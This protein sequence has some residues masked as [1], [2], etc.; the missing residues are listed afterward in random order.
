MRLRPENHGP[1]LSVNVATAI[2][3]GTTSGY[4]EYEAFG[5]IQIVTDTVFT[6]ATCVMAGG[7]GDKPIAAVTY[8]A[9]FILRKYFTTIHLASGVIEMVGL[10]D[11]EDQGLS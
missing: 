1:T 3:A 11:K 5:P 4:E 8:P 6:P 10:T 7:G 2:A 9:G